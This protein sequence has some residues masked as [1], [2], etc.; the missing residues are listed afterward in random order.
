[1]NGF[2]FRLGALLNYR[3]SRRDLCRQLLVQILA[4][5]NRLLSDHRS[6][7]SIRNRQFEEIRSLSHRGRV[8][9]EGTAM[10]RLH[11]GQLLGQLRLVDEKRKLVAQQ[12]KL[13]RDAL[14]KADADV[15]VLERLEDRQRTEFLE[16]LE[17]RAQREREEAWTA[18]WIRENAQ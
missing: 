15:K 6:L 9:V 2:V 3:K 1:M 5:E 12:L 10:R 8:S 17:R 7:T 18:G 4:D 11:S 16:R 14:A 13:C